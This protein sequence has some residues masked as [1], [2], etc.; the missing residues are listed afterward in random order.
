LSA[1]ERRDDE[2][3]KKADTTFTSEG[4]TP[5]KQC[6]TVA[7]AGLACLAL[8]RPAPLAAAAAAGTGTIEGHVR[9]TGPS[10]GNPII[11]MG[12]DPMCSKLNA[13]TRPI[14]EIVLRSADGG[15]ANA[16]VDLEG[17]F[18]A[19]PVPK[20]PVTITQQKCMYKPR[21][22]GA[23]VGQTLRIRNDDGLMHNVHSA[24]SAKNEFDFSQPK[25]GM[26]RDIVL[27]GPDVMMRLKCD[28]HS[29]M[30]AYVG[31]EA[32]PYFAVSKEDGSFTIDGVPV[33]RHRIRV[34]HER[35]GELTQ[36]VTIAAGKKATVD[37][38]YT[39]KEQPKK[40]RLQDLVVP[41]ADSTGILLT[42][43][44]LNR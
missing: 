44:L 16:F 24:S 13:G 19:T 12:M 37:F 4:G 7:I 2:V 30:A 22:I 10:P 27:K 1:A 9:L 36:M 38:S 39:G 6:L 26:V 20:D 18:P 17:T 40:A 32:H 21:V 3:V 14:Q 28:I 29:W 11:R 25:A 35:Y 41:G 8:H 33:G 43:S 23:R 42:T 31:V 5:M 15:L 34:W